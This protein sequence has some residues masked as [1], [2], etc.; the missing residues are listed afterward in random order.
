[1]RAFTLSDKLSM[2]P[3]K[4]NFGNYLVILAYNKLL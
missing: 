3:G 2:M 4:L 1:M